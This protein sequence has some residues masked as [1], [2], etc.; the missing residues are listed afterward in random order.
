MAQQRVLLTGCDGQ[1]GFELQRSVPAQYFSLSA[2]DF[3]KLD[4]THT[5]QIEDVMQSIQPDILIN[6]AAYT[7]VDKAETD[8]DLAWAVNHQ[9]ALNLAKSCSRHGTRMLQVSTD[10]VFDGL[11]STPYTPN[12]PPSPVGVYASSKAAGD[13]AVIKQ[14]HEKALI[15]RT[16][17]L[18]SSH[19]YNFVKTMIR[20]M[21]EKDSLAIVSDQIGTPTWAATLANS[22][23][24]FLKKPDIQG[25]YHCSDSGVASWYDFAIAIQEEALNTGLLKSTI[26]IRPIRTVDYPT[27]AKRPAYS[28]LDKTDTEKLL[29]KSLPHWRTSL[30]K[31]LKEL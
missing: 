2:F 30:R 24:D 5:E 3:A 15:I 18:Y 9:G 6:A 11:Q 22:I 13:E 27:P 14:L 31:M 16:S 29:G 23:W 21:R 20:L 7:Q 26:P 4:I 17:W 12:S 1:L 25:I 28:V 19:G 8:K 10:F